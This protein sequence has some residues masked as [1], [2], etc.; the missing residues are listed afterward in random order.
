MIPIIP[1]MGD[2]RRYLKMRLDKHSTPS[3]T[4]DNSRAEIMR[5]IPGTISEMCVDTTALN[6][7]R[8][9]GYSLIKMDFFSFP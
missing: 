2:I 4:D 9:A 3:A 1:T 8:L 5:V 7:A 6:N